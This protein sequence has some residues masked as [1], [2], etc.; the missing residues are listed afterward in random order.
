MSRL[1]PLTEDRM[2]TAL[3]AE[4][5]AAASQSRLFK[6]V[7]LSIPDTSGTYDL[8]LVDSNYA[9]TF[10]D[11]VYDAFPLKVGASQVSSD[12]SIDKTSITIANVSRDI[13]TY[14]EDYNGLRGQRVKIKSVYETALDFL[15]FPQPDG[16]VVTA[17]N[18]AANNTAFIEDE[19]F[20]DTYTANEQIV[21]FNLEPIIDLNIR[22]PRRRYMTDTC[23]WHYMDED[24]CKYEGISENT[25]TL[26]AGSKELLVEYYAITTDTAPT[27]GT[28]YNWT[29]G[30]SLAVG[31]KVT[32][33]DDPTEYSI[34]SSILNKDASGVIMGW[35][36]EVSPVPTVSVSGSL[37]LL[38]CNK[39]LAS[40]TFRNNVK[41]YG[42]FPGVSG[43]R[44]VLL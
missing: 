39:T 6:L 8:N 37:T 34:T 10:N 36:C 16:T 5:T 28:L 23:Y 41:N 13:M 14:V 15:Y 38:T 18:S 43:V 21:V 42:G 7:S 3:F 1:S 40:C 25:A 9:V 17:D 26:T 12:G 27:V 35:K 24:T 32:I 2:L 31:T 11:V 30:I 20:I 19:Y 29:T 4:E 33:G 22:I 44:R